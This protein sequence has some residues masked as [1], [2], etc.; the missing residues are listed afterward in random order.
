MMMSKI[1]ELEASQNDV[2]E[3]LKLKHFP[4]VEPAD[5]YKSLR[6]QFSAL[7]TMLGTNKEICSHYMDKDYKLSE[8]RLDALEVSLESERAMNAQLTLEIETTSAAKDAAIR[9]VGEALSRVMGNAA[10]GIENNDHE[11]MNPENYNAE[12]GQHRKDV[13]ILKAALT[14]SAAKDAAIRDLGKDLEDINFTHDCPMA[15]EEV[16]F[17]RG[18]SNRVERELKQAIDK[19]KDIIKGVEL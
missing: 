10:Y 2:G 19:H 15:R 17:W 4:N 1:K 7:L 14:T 3:A 13:K 8:K 18:Q 5:N 6:K 12:I 9:D 16:D 11:I